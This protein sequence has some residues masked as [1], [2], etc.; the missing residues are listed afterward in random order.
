MVLAVNWSLRFFLLK[1]YFSEILRLRKRGSICNV[2]FR[3]LPVSV[4]AL[5]LS[6]NS[7]LN[8]GALAAQ[9]RDEQR[10][11]EVSTPEFI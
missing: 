1:R 5:G 2:A 6:L 11:I 4:A 3:E 10:D 7:T 9:Y 8:G